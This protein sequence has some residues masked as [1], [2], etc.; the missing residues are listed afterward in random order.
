MGGLRRVAGA[1]GLLLLVGVTGEHADAQ[2]EAD[3][4][5]VHTFE[6][7]ALGPTS[8][9]HATIY[10]WD[11][12]VRVRLVGQAPL[13]YRDWVRQHL[14]T[15]GRLTELDI[16]LIDSIDA[17]IVVAFVPSFRNVLDGNY[18]GIL[19]RYVADAERRE[20]LL[21]GYRAAN[22]VCAGQVNARGSRLVEAIVFVP[23]DRMAPVVHSCIASQLSRVMGLPFAVPENVPS[24][25]ATDSPYSH[26][27]PLDRLLLRMLYHPRMQPGLDREDAVIVATSILPELRAEEN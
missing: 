14:A 4:D 15:L 7:A 19:D 9:S 27:A 3:R 21:S 8:Q 13:A 23:L 16:Q 12:A 24:V 20:S 10:R 1:L 5:L 25:L 22:A 26:L 18:N 11:G 2:S 6:T 17:D